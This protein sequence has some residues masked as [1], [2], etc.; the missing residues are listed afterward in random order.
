[1]SVIVAVL[2]IF[3][4]G[5]VLWSNP[6][7]QINKI[8]FSLSIHV[9]IWFAIRQLAAS[10]TDALFWVRLAIAVG[11]LI[12]AHLRLFMQAIAFST[13][14]RSIGTQVIKSWAWI[15][16]GVLLA[17]L[18]FSNGFIP[19]DSIPGSNRVGPL[20]MIHFCGLIFLYILLMYYTR[21]VS[22]RT[23]GVE[24]L[25]LNLIL[26]GGAFAAFLVLGL[27]LARR[28]L[29]I[30]LSPHLQPLV[31]LLLFSSLCLL[32]TTKKIFDAKYIL[33]VSI[34]GSLVLLATS[35]V[36]YCIARVFRGVLAAWLV[37][38]V[39]AASIIALYHPL[40]SYC[41]RMLRM[42]PRLSDMLRTVLD[43]AQHNLDAS[44]L[45][46]EFKNALQAW[47]QAEHVSIYNIRTTEKWEKR[48]ELQMLAP[49]GT[50]LIESTWLTQ[51]R[52][53]RERPSVDREYALRIFREN[54]IGA[55]VCCNGT[56]SC[57]VICIGD[58]PSRRPY[59]YP[60]IRSLIEISGI[61][62]AS[63]ARCLLAERAHDAERLATVGVVGAGVAHEIRN[64]LVTIKTF[65]QLLPQKYESEEFREKFFR[66]IGKE[67]GRIEDLTEQLLDLA[68]PRKY[69]LEAHSL[70]SLLSDSI[71]LLRLRGSRYAVEVINAFVASND[72]VI[73]DGNAVKQI[74]LNLCLNAMQA[75]EF[76]EGKRWIKM[77]T[78]V[79]DLGVEL[80]VSDNGSGIREEARGRLFQAF[81]TSKSTGI[82]L[83][84]VICG[85]I[86][87]SIGASIS[88]DDYSPGKGATFR[89]VFPCQQ[90][91]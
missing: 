77:E 63:F 23:R 2:V 48:P 85:Q 36:V 8:A 89:I 47:S 35:I 37:A 5:I 55:A 69:I 74:V 49:I 68:S 18:T 39:T 64:P 32:I 56:M 3:W 27:M 54:G 45:I 72:R 67:V 11:D 76:Q 82:G 53:V 84:L 42:P 91:I 29:G 78:S 75:Q 33:I 25:E 20:Y 57:I 62:E 70:H 66:L 65:V 19:R 60:E 9:A 22:K 61:M 24:K 31:I 21:Q 4:G 88:L 87:K 16:S 15:L 28:L 81:Q 58:R 59:T 13:G 12:P 46:V 7:R 50:L 30:A 73:T 79:T 26:L 43:I 38:G 71:E 83:G 90:S 10:S 80:A 40:N 41:S 34:R 86:V 6:K 1:M 52:L 17:A 51:E 14:Q 44:R